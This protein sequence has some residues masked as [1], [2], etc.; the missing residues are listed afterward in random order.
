MGS[1]GENYPKEQA[2]CR[3]LLQNYRGIGQ[4]GAFAHAELSKLLSRADEALVSGNLM[5][6]ICCYEEMREWNE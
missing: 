1:L 3:E 6:M 4:P 5:D 2:R